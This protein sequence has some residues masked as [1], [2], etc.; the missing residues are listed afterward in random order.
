M[1]RDQVT[2]GFLFVFTTA[3]QVAIRKIFRDFPEAVEA[4]ETGVRPI[5]EMLVL[6]CKGLVRS[7]EE[8]QYVLAGLADR[9]VGRTITETDTW[10]EA[11][12]LRTAVIDLM[13]RH[14][15]ALARD[16]FVRR[17]LQG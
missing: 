4:L 8:A 13:T 7:E 3:E 17:V 6:A 15:L 12:E 14:L 2:D 5:L 1:E 16:E 11:D 9:I 10:G